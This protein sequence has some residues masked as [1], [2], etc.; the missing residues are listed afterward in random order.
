[1]SFLAITNYLLFF[2]N[3]LYED[4]PWRASVY[5]LFSA[6][7]TADGGTGYDRKKRMEPS[8]TACVCG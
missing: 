6:N 3:S 7:T 2:V 1:M 5:L 8:G 4:I